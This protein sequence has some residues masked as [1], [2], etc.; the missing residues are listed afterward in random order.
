VERYHYRH[1]NDLPEF[2]EG[3]P[4]SENIVRTVW[5]L[6]EKALGEGTLHRVRLAETRDNAFE[7]FG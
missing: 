6:L 1:L 4:T 3:V 7:Y 2:A 5:R